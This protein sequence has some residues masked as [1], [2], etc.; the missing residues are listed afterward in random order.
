MGNTR[1]SFFEQKQDDVDVWWSNST[2]NEIE[3]A[4]PI[5]IHE[6]KNLSEE[7]VRKLD[8]FKLKLARKREKRK[9][10][11]HCK[12]K[13]MEELREE[14]E[15]L[16]QEN[17][18]LR[19]VQAV[20]EE[21]QSLG[22]GS[23]NEVSEEIRRLREENAALRRVQAISGKDDSEISYKISRLEQ[24]NETLKMLSREKDHLLVESEKIIEKNCELRIETVRMQQELQRL[25]NEMLKFEKERTDY[26][27]H[28]VA[29]KD[30]I[31]V[32]KN[33]LQIRETELTEVNHFVLFLY[34]NVCPSFICSRSK[35]YSLFYL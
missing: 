17:E 35:S 4:H 3:V 22:S 29:L 20:S 23:G 8:E 24:E 5:E 11:I 33:M 15:R 14:I 31:A 30:V 18:T 9:E 21:N 1:S 34:L 26:K 12:T 28:V 27:A 6:I 2:T 10:I 19:R 7:S 25:N 16:K 32:S 13:K